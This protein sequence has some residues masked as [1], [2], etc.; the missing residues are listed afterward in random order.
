LKNQGGS[1]PWD[2]DMDLPYLGRDYFVFKE[3]FLEAQKEL[4][5]RLKRLGKDETKYDNI[6]GL[7]TGPGFDGK[8][9]GFH[10][11]SY[12]KSED[13]FFGENKS[14]SK[15]TKVNIDGQYFPTNYNPAKFLRKYGTEIFQHVEHA[16][17]VVYSKGYSDLGKFKECGIKGHHSCLENFRADG[18]FQFKDFG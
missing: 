11:D 17:T 8:C 15:L 2:T 5:I 12:G 3:H 9:N 1:L 13:Y 16:K 6:T 14:K 7:T 4:G 18:N 10:L